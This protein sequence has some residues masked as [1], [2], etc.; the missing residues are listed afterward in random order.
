LVDGFSRSGKTSLVVSPILNTP[1][2]A[3]CTVGG[4]CQSTASVSI[5]VL[6]VPHL[7]LQTLVNKA[8]AQ[9]G[10][11]LTYSVIV[12]NTGLAA[13]T[14][15]IVEEYLSAKAIYIPNS[16]TTSTGTFTAGIP[17]N[18]WAIASIP[19]NSS[20]T[21]AYSASVVGEGIVTNTGTIS[22]AG[23]GGGLYINSVSGMCWE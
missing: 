13:A 12:T 1:Y 2:S 6:P 5:T 21:L 8:Q 15:V 11:V 3:T 4:T 7:S 14:N 17:T 9:L 20:A 10:E 18:T 19:A 22:N 23:Y 16:A